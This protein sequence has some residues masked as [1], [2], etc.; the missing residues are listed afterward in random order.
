[1]GTL[2]RDLCALIYFHH[3]NLTCGQQAF[4][5]VPCM[6]AQQP[7]LAMLPLLSAHTLGP[8]PIPEVCIHSA[9]RVLHTLFFFPGSVCAHLSV[10][11][12]LILCFSL[13]NHFI[14]V[15]YFIYATVLSISEPGTSKYGTL[16]YCEKLRKLQKP[17]GHLPQHFCVRTGHKGVLC[18]TSPEDRS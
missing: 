5:A 17:K 13:C 9:M 10:Q 1:M 15:A 2:L 4:H 8:S 11:F 6:P 3:S 7:H 12:Q 18:P 14:Y 16:T